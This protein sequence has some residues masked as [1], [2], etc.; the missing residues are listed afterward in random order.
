MV[1]DDPQV[2]DLVRQ[3]L[4]GEPYE[5]TAAVD[6]QAALDAI[7][8]QQPDIVLLDLLMPRLD[9]FAVIE[10][11]RQDSDHRA[12][13]IIVLTAKTLTASEHTRLDQSV[14]T[15]IQKRGLERSTLIDEL[16]S[17]LQDS[18]DPIPQGGARGRTASD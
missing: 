6:G 13:P 3:L 14:R 9:G 11:L 16:Q 15:V 7:D 18:R 17:L 4:E 8:Q 12:L 5:V 1:D 10:H 2:V